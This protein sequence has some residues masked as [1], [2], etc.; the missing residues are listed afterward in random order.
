MR[1]VGVVVETVVR[2]R[3]DMDGDGAQPG[4]GVQHVVTGSLGDLES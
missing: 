2:A 3:V 1:E 4:H